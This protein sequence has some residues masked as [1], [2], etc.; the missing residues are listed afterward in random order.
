MPAWLDKTATLP[1]TEILGQGYFCNLWK[2]T[3]FGTLNGQTGAWVG[4]SGPLTKTYNLTLVCTATGAKKVAVNVYRAYNAADAQVSINN[5]KVTD[6]SNVTTT[7]AQGIT[8]DMAA[9]NGNGEIRSR[10]FLVPAI[11]GGKIVFNI[12]STIGTTN[13]SVGV[14]LVLGD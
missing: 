12:T 7:Y 14:Y 3:L 10:G 2:G 13:P 4:G 11:A 1:A 5:I 8:I 6:A 9:T